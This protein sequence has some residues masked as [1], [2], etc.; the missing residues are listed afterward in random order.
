MFCVI[1]L[2]TTTHKICRRQTLLC[3]SKKQEHIVLMKKANMGASSQLNIST[4]FVGFHTLRI[5]LQFKSNYLPVQ[6]IT[7]QLAPCEL[8]SLAY[9]NSLH[10]IQQCPCSRGTASLR[11]ARP[12]ALL[13]WRSQH[14]LLDAA[15]S[16]RILL[17]ARPRRADGLQ[18]DCPSNCSLFK[19]TDRQAEIQMSPC[20]Y[21]GD[22]DNVA[23]KQVLSQFSCKQR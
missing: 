19:D 10:S 6:V 9:Q 4:N 17:P 15:Y 14:S 12:L 13:F 21:Q 8:T 1:Q 2:L 16:L 20:D 22:I 3:L 23:C 7:I 11:N 18:V 5:N